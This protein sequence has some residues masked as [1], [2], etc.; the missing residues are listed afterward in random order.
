MAVRGS[1]SLSRS[2]NNGGPIGPMSRE[3]RVGL[4][5][6]AELPD[7]ERVLQAGRIKSEFPLAFADAFAGSHRPGAPR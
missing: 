5:V 3:H 2:S 1:I 7:D 6:I 4:V